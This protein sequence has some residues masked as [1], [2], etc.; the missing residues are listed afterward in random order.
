[1][2]ARNP[3]DFV[4]RR[5]VLAS[6]S[7]AAFLF[8]PSIASAEVSRETFVHA[9]GS[10]IRTTGATPELR[11]RAALTSKSVSGVALAATDTMRFGDGDTI[12]RFEQT[13]Q[14][15]P[16]IGRGA[17]VRL[18]KNG[19][20]LIVAVDVE[21]E[22]PQS[23]LPAIA[24][25]AAARTAATLSKVGADESDAHLVVWPLRGGGARLA[26]AVVPTVPTG[27]PT[28]PRI[29]VDAIS[30]KV[31]EAR[32]MLV[33]AKAQVYQFNPIK[34]PNLSL[35]DLALDP[36]A[37]GLTNPF[38][39][40]TNCLDN[41]TVKPVSFGAFK[42]N[43][44]VCDLVQTAKPDASGNYVYTPS[45]DPGS[46]AARSDTFSEVSMYY[47]A[48]K[49]YGFFR[50]LQGDDA[51]QVV[52]DKPLPVI[53]NL[54]IPAGI[55]QGNIA[56]A[57][58]PNQKL[59]P[60]QNA[61][62][63]PAVGGLGQLFEQLY[64]MKSGALWFGQGPQR[65][66]SYDGDVI[67]HEFTHAVVDHTIKLGAWHID[68]HGAIDAPGAMN[69]G[70]ADYFSSAITGDPDVG[71]YASKD[72]SPNL[73]VIRSLANSD[74]C[75]TNIIGEVHADSTLFSGALWDARTALGEADRP[76]FDA[77]LYKALRTNPGRGDVGYDDVAKLFLATLG[78][79][80]P[81]G[82]AALQ[83]SMTARG[84]LPSCDRVLELGSGGL[85]A[86]DRSLGGFAAPGLQSV[87]L[88]DLAPG[89][90]QVHV[91]FGGTAM[92]TINVS[93]TVRDT[94]GG[95]GADI[96]GGGGTPYAPVVL[97]K[98]GKAITWTDAG[99]HDADVKTNAT[100]GTR[101]TAAIA[102][103]DGA[104][105]VF[106]Q[107]ANSGDTDGNYDDVQAELVPADVPPPDDGAQPPAAAPAPSS[108]SGC[109]CSTPGTAPSSVPVTALGAAAALGL[110]F[111]AR[112]RRARAR[113]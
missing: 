25:S 111:A 30:G 48:S 98:F 62:F 47:H 87:G 23:I 68:S 13:H 86:I 109:A 41:H 72:I 65:D 81:A 84:V 91:P 45:D 74:K 61:F 40:S 113:T 102:V 101:Y 56:L 37:D 54:Q 90:L 106:L 7:L 71:E 28:A 9:R 67:Y 78:T 1:L 105:E 75:P 10:G 73:T 43:V 46:D 88:T 36:A 6:L 27:I 64:G 31:I 83:A 22:L 26:W 44:H 32:D 59:D 12:V 92:T 79:D 8:V 80:L 53:A 103:P 52:D 112:R 33:F 42:T 108:D 16:V 95:A 24:A 82:Q 4:M 66:Y 34:T 15:L 93:F 50:G 29:I 70:L 20:A 55:T 2:L 100:K 85:K 38:V 49:A 39:R 76:K 11:A 51:A 63:S 3:E 14:G 57:A 104:T 35:F 110:V 17:A 21:R 89:I 77:A 97:A 5:S 58:D 94:G 96:L 107:I 99:K 19:E 60:F 69:E 18:G